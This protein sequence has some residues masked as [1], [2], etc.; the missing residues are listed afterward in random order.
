MDRS[1]SMVKSMWPG[2]SIRLMRN[3]PQRQ[4]VAVAVMVI[5]R[6]CSWGIQSMTAWPLCTSPT[7]WVSPL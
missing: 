2:V 1:T 7:L 3:S 6:S 5:P 4:V